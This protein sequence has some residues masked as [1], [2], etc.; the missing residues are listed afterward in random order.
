MILALMGKAWG[1]FRRF[2]TRINEIAAVIRW[3]PSWIVLTACS[4]SSGEPMDLKADVHPVLSHFG[5][6]ASWQD[7]GNKEVIEISRKAG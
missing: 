5:F 2:F 4:C 6:S 7:K 3:Q 1:F